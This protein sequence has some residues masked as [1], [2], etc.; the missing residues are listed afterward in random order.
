MLAAALAKVLVVHI[1]TYSLF[2]DMGFVVAQTKS[3]PP[4][5]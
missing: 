5:I 3:N 4:V 1:A 2:I